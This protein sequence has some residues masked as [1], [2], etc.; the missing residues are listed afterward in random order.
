MSRNN[1]RIIEWSKS[2]GKDGKEK[3]K[4]IRRSVRSSGPMKNKRI[5]S[6]IKRV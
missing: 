1:R 6:L 5:G 4:V 3:R 2:S